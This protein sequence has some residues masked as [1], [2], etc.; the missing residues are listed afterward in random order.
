[1]YTLI[2]TLDIPMPISPI[3]RIKISPE[4]LSELQRILRLRKLEQAIALRVK[5]IIE[6]HNGTSIL[7]T[8][9]LLNCHRETVRTWRKRWIERHEDHPIM[10]LLQENPRPGAVPK[11]TPE[12]ICQIVALSCTKPED[13][14]YCISH[15]SETALAKAATEKGIV[16]SIS[17]RQVGRFLKS[18][19][20]K[21]R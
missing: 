10:E 6:A 18:G 4:K 8:A 1:M 7:K 16:E 2:S 9:Q 21:T 14:G 15:W 11:F 3:P 13:S 20:Y 5:I 17:Q 12:Q 19:R